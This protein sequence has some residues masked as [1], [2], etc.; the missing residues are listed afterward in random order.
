MSNRDINIEVLK[1]FR[2][3]KA[4]KGGK[5]KNVV[6]IHVKSTGPPDMSNHNAIVKVFKTA[7]S[8][9]AF[10]NKYLY[11]DFSYPVDHEDV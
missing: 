4:K 7:E 6:N 10:R 8:Y 1:E 2:K 9:E 5:S 11:S 3:R